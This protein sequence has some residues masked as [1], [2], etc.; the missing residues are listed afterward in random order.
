[1]Q[2][3]SVLNDRLFEH[4]TIGL[5]DC[6]YLLTHVYKR[7]GKYVIFAGQKAMSTRHTIV[8]DH[9]ELTE[10]NILCLQI[11]LSA[12]QKV[13]GSSYRRAILRI[14]GLEPMLRA[15]KLCC[16]LHCDPAW[17][18][19]VL[20]LKDEIDLNKTYVSNAYALSR[21]KIMPKGMV[22][23]AETEHPSTFVPKCVLLNKEQR[24]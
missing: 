3:R 19:K 13:N 14:L 2:T 23:D 16:L 18:K 4:H 10:L 22:Q 9:G 12:G 5:P 24:R 20:G 8:V 11:I 7:E 6:D 17:L 21:L 15:E 1:M